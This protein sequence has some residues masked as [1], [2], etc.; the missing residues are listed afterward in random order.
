MKFIR[1][2]I[3]LFVFSA[4]L[5]G[6]SLGEP[7]IKL[8]ED[9]SNAIA[10]YCAHLIMKYGAKGYYNQKLLD[11]KD[12]DDALEEREAELNPSPTPTPKVTPT[13]EPGP[14]ITQ[15]PD[16]GE[17]GDNGNEPTNSGQEPTQD[18]STKVADASDLFDPSVFE[19]SLVGYEFT[20]NYKNELEYFTLSAPEGKLVAAFTLEVKNITSQNKVFDY[21]N[22]SAQFQLVVDSKSS[23]GPEISLL[24]NDFR[25]TRSEIKP[26]ESFKGV[27]VFFID[28]KCKEFTFRIIGGS[29]AYE[30]NN[31]AEVENGN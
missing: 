5:T 1:Y 3:I 30:Y 9:E 2:L 21:N 31:S 6:C 16:G 7:T 13:P 8:T 26:G 23:V 10:Q 12:Y 17:G 18:P 28:N 24:S 4:V 11:E 14:D 25:F 27:V 15:A 22:Y 29:K 20:K 19:V